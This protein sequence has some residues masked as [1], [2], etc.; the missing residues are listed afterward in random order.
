[1]KKF[2]S[3]IIMVAMILTLVSCGS[4]K[5][6]QNN[7]SQSASNE[8]TQT[9]TAENTKDANASTTENKGN[10][11]ETTAN[12]SNSK[13]LIV[14]FSRVGATN[15]SDKVD[16]V[17]SASLNSGKNG[18][19]GNAEIIANIIKEETNGDVFQIKT[20]DSYSE[21]Y[22]DTVDQAA[23]EKKDNA[24]PKLSS[25]VDNMDNYDII[26]LVYPNWWGTIPM[27]VYTFLEEYNFSGKTIMPLC[28]HEGSAMG[29]SK[30]DIASL[31]P[32][33]KLLDGL[34]IRGRD[35]NSSNTKESV[36]DWIKKSGIAN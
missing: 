17:A 4:A 11:Q 26:F 12:K 15:F 13:T 10:T 5:E 19:V 29:S 23:K 36:N 2:L 14:Y 8:T 21:T 32:N 6:E 30:G 18:L 22:G 28:T 27:P 35:V 1:M 7:V 3:I 33:A 20:V 34:A 25:H 16:V 24:R 9:K 31:C